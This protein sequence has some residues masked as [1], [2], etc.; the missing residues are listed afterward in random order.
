MNVFALVLSILIMI[1]G[2]VGCLL[3]AL[4]GIPLVFLGILGYGWAEGFHVISGK[5]LAIMGA[6]TLLSV[7]V[8]Y[9]SGVWGAKSFGSSKYGMIGALL[10]AVVG[11]FFGPIGV[12]VGPLAGAFIGEYVVLQDPSKAAYSAIGT[13]LGIFA[14]IVF[15]IVLGLGMLISFL[16][17]VF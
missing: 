12:F 7:L 8:D 15:K 16:V 14:G 4:P 9:L 6:L 1:I 5:Y 3:P 2:I 17:V 11:I 10:G 13:I